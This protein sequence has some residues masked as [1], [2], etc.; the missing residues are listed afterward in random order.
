MGVFQDN[1]GRFQVISVNWGRFQVNSSRFQ[2][3]SNRSHITSGKI[4]L[5][6]DH[7][8]TIMGWSQV[9]ICL[10]QVKPIEYNPKESGVLQGFVLG[11]LYF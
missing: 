4:E 11:P 8:Q 9:I 10:I 1:S 3:N 5:N 6:S 7:F 2:A